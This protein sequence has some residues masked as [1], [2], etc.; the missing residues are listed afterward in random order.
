MTKADLRRRFGCTFSC[1][2]R[3][4]RPPHV[5]YNVDNLR[6]ASW[7]WSTTAVAIV[8]AAL[9]LAAGIQALVFV[10]QHV[11]EQPAT[12]EAARAELAA[13]EARFAGEPPLIDVR[14]GQ[15]PVVRR[16]KPVGARDA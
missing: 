6:D 11:Q 14:D 2:R 4:D 15:E 1:G 10:F 16:T 9:M 3:F 12:A 13:V 5:V 7:R 8:G